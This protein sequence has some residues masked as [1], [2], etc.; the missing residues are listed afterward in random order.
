MTN[1]DKID[2]DIETAKHELTL[3]YG[4]DIASLASKLLAA[5]CYLFKALDEAA[6]KLAEQTRHN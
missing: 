1:A 5:V 2:S 3:L 4:E 6:D